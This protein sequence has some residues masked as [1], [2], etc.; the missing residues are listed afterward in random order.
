M[1]HKVLWIENKGPQHRVYLFQAE[2][3]PTVQYLQY[4][5]FDWYKTTAFTFS[6]KNLLHDERNISSVVSTRHIL[7]SS[8]V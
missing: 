5:V 8:T 3:R 1:R 2:S 4:H 6:H 7:S